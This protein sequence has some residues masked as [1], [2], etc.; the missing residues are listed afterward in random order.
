MISVVINGLLATMIIKFTLNDLAHVSTYVKTSSMTELPTKQQ[1][2]TILYLN[3]ILGRKTTLADEPRTLV[4]ANR[5][6][7]DLK[8]LVAKYHPTFIL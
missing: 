7:K 3:R 1:R 5:R 6:I 2:R 8:A 4:E